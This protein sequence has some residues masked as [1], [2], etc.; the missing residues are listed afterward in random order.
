MLPASWRIRDSETF[1]LVVRQGRRHGGRY[2]VV[3]AFRSEEAGYRVGFVVSKSV[4][5][6]V[7]RNRVKRRL[8]HIVADLPLLPGSCL[9]VRAL[10]R[11]SQASFDE[12]HAELLRQLKQTPLIDQGT[13]Q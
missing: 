8:R 13:N 12:M 6:A 9:V 3:H 11:S 10:P 2:C 1:R 5:N 7:V 4:G